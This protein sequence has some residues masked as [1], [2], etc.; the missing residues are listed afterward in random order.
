MCV[1]MVDYGKALSRFETVPKLAIDDDDRLANTDRERTEC[2]IIDEPHFDSLEPLARIAP[3]L[4]SPTF[5]VKN[6][7]QHRSAAPHH[8]GGREGAERQRKAER[9]RREPRVRHTEMWMMSAVRE[10][11]AVP[12]RV[13]HQDDEQSEQSDEGRPKD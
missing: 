5:S 3:K 7:S 2:Q 10:A 9:G 11:V 6:V 12:Q 4:S 1:L 13:G 8:E